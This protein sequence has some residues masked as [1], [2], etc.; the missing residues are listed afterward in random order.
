MAKAKARKEAQPRP[1]EIELAHTGDEALARL[2]DL[3]RR[4][5]AVPKSEIIAREKRAKKKRPHGNRNG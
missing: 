5:I 2:T 1:E 4:V 3:T